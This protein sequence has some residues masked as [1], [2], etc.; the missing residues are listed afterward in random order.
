M[1]V[2]IQPD[3]DAIRIRDLVGGE[4]AAIDLCH[5]YEDLRA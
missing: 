5:V 1:K 3:C 4:L 2:A